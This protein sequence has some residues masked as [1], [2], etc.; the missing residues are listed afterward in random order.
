VLP[1]FGEFTGFAD[2]E[3]LPGDRVWI[4]ANDQLI[5]VGN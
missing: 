5:S 1:A 2:V 4:V 3:P